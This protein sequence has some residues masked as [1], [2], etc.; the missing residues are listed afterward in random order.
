MH[1]NTMKSHFAILLIVV[2]A[3]ANPA[4]AQESDKEAIK[5]VVM[6]ET[7]SYLGVDKEAWA[8]TWWP[9]PYAYWLFSDKSGTQYLE[10]WDTIEKTFESYFK[11]QKPSRSRVTYTWQEI[12]VYGNGAY[13][14][15]KEHGD[16]NLRIEETSQLRVLEKRDGKWK[17]ICMSAAVNMD[18]DQP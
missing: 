4:L 18:N 12:R 6:Q 14:R 7:E 17:I 11:G 16:D 2:L 13:V 9:V 15:F 8:S 5:R 1:F 3:A 10:G